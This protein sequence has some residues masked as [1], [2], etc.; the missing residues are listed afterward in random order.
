MGNKWERTHRSQ[1]QIN[2]LFKDSWV[3]LELAERFSVLLSGSHS[4]GSWFESR[5]RFLLN[6]YEL[7][8]GLGFFYTAGEM[9]RIKQTHDHYFIYTYAHTYT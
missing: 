1:V 3:A 2:I 6:G 4:E 5:Y 8:C 9:K 7:K